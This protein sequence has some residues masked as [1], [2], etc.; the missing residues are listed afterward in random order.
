MADQAMDGEGAADEPDGNSHDV[1]N[2]QTTV[3]DSILD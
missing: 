3:N 1:A 2:W